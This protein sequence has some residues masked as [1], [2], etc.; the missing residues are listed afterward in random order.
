MVSFS[1]S[2]AVIA[3]LTTIAIAA[4]S[5]VRYFDSMDDQIKDQQLLIDKLQKELK[6]GGNES[7]GPGSQPPSSPSLP[8]PTSAPLQDRSPLAPAPVAEEPSPVVPAP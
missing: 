4:V 8:A 1:K 7:Q 5:A 2:L 6:G 3:S